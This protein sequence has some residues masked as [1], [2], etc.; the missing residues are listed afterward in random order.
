MSLPREKPLVIAHRG[1]SGHLPENTMPAYELAVTQRADM[2]EID[3]H[4]TRDGAVV[5][6]HD[7]V[8]DGLGGEG[9]IADATCDYVR[10]LDAGDGERVPLLDEVLDRFAPRIPF[11][12]ELKVGTQGPYPGLE[13]IALDAARSRGVLDATLFSSF[14][15]AVLGTLRRESE[16]ARLGVLVSGR[17]PQGWLERARAVGA[18]AVNFWVGLATQEAVDA[19]HAAGLAVNVYTV[20]DVPTL[21]AL[22]ARQVDGIF[23]NVPDRLRS[24][25]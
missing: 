18:E 19:A 17:A 11:N 10:G 13:R 5:I 9:E 22:I 20:D 16:S 12:L 8:L 21:E 1:A 3:L 15:D 2:I 6:T 4:R 14:S 23:T 7:E 25:L 24:L